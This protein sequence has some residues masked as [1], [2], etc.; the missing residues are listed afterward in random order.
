MENADKLYSVQD[1]INITASLIGSQPQDLIE[2]IEDNDLSTS[3]NLQSFLKPFAVSKLNNLRKESLDKGFRQAS[4]RVEK[5]W[6]EVFNEDIAGK[7][8]DD[9]FVQHRDKITS[10]PSKDKSKITLQQALQSDE[11]RTHIEQLKSKATTA[12]TVQSQFDKYKQLMSIKSTALEELTNR[13]AKFSPNPKVKA[14]QMQALESELSS[15]KVKVNNDGSVTLLDEDGESP[16]YN[17]ETASHWNFGD[18][19]QQNS[20]LDFGEIEAP[21]KDKNTFT[22]ENKG[23]LGSTFGY[24][25]SQLAGLGYADW[26]RA[27]KAGKTEEAAFIQKQMIE[28][29]E[30]QQQK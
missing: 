21:K 3:D 24:S 16:L 26:E 8:L 22:P 10:T 27:N 15:L 6:G 29:H 1:V 5:L 25:K 19:L 2:K 17:T 9:L 7:K 28:N 12:E 18:Y 30:Q 23:S 11:V 13:G 20:P 4:K 14:L